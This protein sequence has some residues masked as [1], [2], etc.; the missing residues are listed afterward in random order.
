MS[1]EVFLTDKKL[2]VTESFEEVTRLLSTEPFPVFSEIGGDRVAVNPRSVT[3]V[4][5][6]DDHRVPMRAV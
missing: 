6:Q 1:T 3:E 2:Y 5:F 4:R